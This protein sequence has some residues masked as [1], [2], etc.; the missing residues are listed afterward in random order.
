MHVET[1][2]ALIY[3]RD[4]ASKQAPDTWTKYSSVRSRKRSDDKKC[5]KARFLGAPFL[6]P[7]NY[8]VSNLSDNVSLFS[9]K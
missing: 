4:I 2:K 8:I 1:F 7:L 6:S 9:R 5:R 3:V